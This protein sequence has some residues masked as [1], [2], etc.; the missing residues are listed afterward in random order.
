MP[1]ALCPMPYALC[2]LIKRTPHV[3]EKG[4]IM[5]SRLT[6]ISRSGQV[7]EMG[8][9]WQ[10]WLVRGAPTKIA[11]PRPEMISHTL[12]LIQA[13]LLTGLPPCQV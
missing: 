8:D 12:N 3:T 13:G 2:P 6:I 10:V 5:S 1:Y 9:C 11:V 4:Y 7:F